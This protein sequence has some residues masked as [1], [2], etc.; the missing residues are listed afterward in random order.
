MQNPTDKLSSQ[1]RTASIIVRVIG[2]VNILGGLFA[3]LILIALR[4]T[5]A[6]SEPQ[7]ELA[8]SLFM[9]IIPTGLL[10]GMAI[11]AAGIGLARMKRWARALTEGLAWFFGVF[12]F[13]FAFF[14]AGVLPPFPFPARIFVVVFVLLSILVWLIPVGLAIRWLRKAA[15]RQAFKENA[16]GL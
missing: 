6:G 2:A 12:I 15:V 14:F 3:V 1:I 5:Q 9:G 13:G 8:F 7:A 16:A 4:A 11:M 10:L